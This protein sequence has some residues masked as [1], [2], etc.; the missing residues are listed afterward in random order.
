L[1]NKR[2]FSTRV[3]HEEKLVTGDRLLVTFACPHLTICKNKEAQIVRVPGSSGEFGILF[4]HVPTIAELKPGLVTIQDKQGVETKHFISG[5]FA[6]V[7]KDSTCS[8]NAIEAFSLDE[9]D[10]EAAKEGYRRFTADL[11]KAPND[12]ERAKALI[13]LEVHQAMCSALGVTA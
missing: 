4:N 12:L 9:L 2:L 8:V 10:P 3:E 1:S 13:G 7:Q 11:A 6:F 5:G